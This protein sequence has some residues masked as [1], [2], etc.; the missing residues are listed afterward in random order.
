MSFPLVRLGPK[1]AR[2]TRVLEK[3][4]TDAERQAREL[5]IRKAVRA[6][7]GKCR[8]PEKHKCRCELECAHVTD[9]SLGG[10][11]EPENLVLLCGWI[12]RRGPESIHGKELRMEH[13]GLDPLG[14]PIFSFWK[15][16]GGGAYYLLAREV[17]PFV[18]ERD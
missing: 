11:Y 8:W 7:D 6:R 4:R 17:A 5:E 2:G 3:E 15:Q 14:R 18:F 9:A 1:P 16:D 13:E 12:H 10:A